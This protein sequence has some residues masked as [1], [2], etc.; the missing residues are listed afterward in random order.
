MKFISLS[1]SLILYAIPVHAIPF[2]PETAFSWQTQVILL[3]EHE[4]TAKLAQ[5]PREIKLPAPTTP[6]EEWQAYVDQMPGLKGARL[7][8]EGSVKVPNPGY[9]ASLKKAEKQT[10]PEWLQLEVHYQA[11]QGD[12]IWPTVITPKK[13]DYREDNYSGDH[14][15][16]VIQLPDKDKIKVKIETVQ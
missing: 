5:D 14:Q 9:D 8:V 1:L 4:K 2:I 16:V 11:P 7:I 6:K 3:A 12:Q 15:Y 13:V 10:K